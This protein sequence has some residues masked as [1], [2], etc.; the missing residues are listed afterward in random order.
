M[1][2]LNKSAGDGPSAISSA[3]VPVAAPVVFDGA[4]ALMPSRDG[5][6]T[7]SKLIDIYMSAYSGQDASRHQ[8]LGFWIAKLGTLRVADLT[9]DHVFYALEDLAAMRGRYW[10]GTDADGRT[11][12]KAKR[13]PLAPATINRYAAALGAVLTFGIK[14]RLA[15]RGWDNPL[16]RIERRVE[17]NEVVRY[18]SDA[19]RTALMTSCRASKWPK[20]Y[21][22][23]LLA[24]T[25]GARRG[26]LERMRW[27]DMDLDRALCVVS[28]TKNGDPKI[29][30]LVPA[31]IEELHLH[32]GPPGALVFASTR[33]PDVAYNNVAVWQRALKAAGV[34]NFRFHDLRH[35][36]ASYLAQNGATLLEIGDV[37][38]H[39]QLSVTKRYSHL[40]TKNKVDLINRVLGELR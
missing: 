32:I 19:E 37:L 24:L 17:D 8:R 20:L 6:I 13:K 23:V 30:P 25:T 35:S 5:S 3:T 14:K 18:L 12:F 38:G 26:E 15:P 34:R 1:E 33:R 4:A 2:T 27:R 16:R 40:T 21:L 10:A 11:I 36:C 29:V 31:V 39:R 28:K 22:L 9:D 7:I